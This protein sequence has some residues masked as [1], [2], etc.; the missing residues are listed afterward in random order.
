[1]EMVGQQGPSVTFRPG[2]NE[3]SGKTID[4]VLPVLVVAKDVAPFY[5]TNDYM[6]KDTGNVNSRETWHARENSKRLA[7]LSTSQLRPAFCYVP[8]SVPREN[9]KLS[10]E[11]R[12]QAVDEL[13]G[14]VAD[15]DGILQAQPA[16]DV[17]YFAKNCQRAF[18]EQDLERINGIV[19]HAYRWQYI[20]SGVEDP[21][22]QALIG[23]MLTPEQADR[24]AQALG[25]LKME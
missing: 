10:A 1:M 20:F 14:L 17:A 25:G 7:D 8:P 24:I 18:G 21:R 23:G 5:P 12:D 9:E 13:I 11:E 6:L 3:E 15:F 19:L 2:F 16:S 22:F 4:Q